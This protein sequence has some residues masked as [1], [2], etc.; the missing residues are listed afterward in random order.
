MSWVTS[1]N[2]LKTVKK[3]EK[4]KKNFIAYVTRKVYT[5]IQDQFTRHYTQFRTFPKEFLQ[6]EKKKHHLSESKKKTL[7]T[8]TLAEWMKNIFNNFLLLIK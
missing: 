1:F 6:K 3:M 5:Q 4:K 2:E 7:E 8:F